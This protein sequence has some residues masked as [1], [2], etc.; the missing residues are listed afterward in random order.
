MDRNTGELLPA[1]TVTLFSMK[2]AIISK[3]TTTDNKSFISFGIKGR[4]VR[5]QSIRPIHGK[6]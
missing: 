5:V 2:D 4:T 3:G 1:S 6:K